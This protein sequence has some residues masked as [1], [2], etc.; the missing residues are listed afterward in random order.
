MRSSI[1]LSWQ[2]TRQSSGIGFF[3][4]ISRLYNHMHPR[5]FLP[6]MKVLLGEVSKQLHWF[7][8]SW[9]QKVQSLNTSGY[10]IFRLGEKCPT[11]QLDHHLLATISG[12]Q[13]GFGILRPKSVYTGYFNSWTTH[14]GVWI[15]HPRPLPTSN[16]WNRIIFRDKIGN[17]NVGKFPNGQLIGWSWLNWFVLVSFG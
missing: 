14:G 8:L 3:I 10:W 15:M 1:H 7:S 4:E 9:T 6:S 17:H 16:S 12:S 11:A 5:N 2:L 13:S